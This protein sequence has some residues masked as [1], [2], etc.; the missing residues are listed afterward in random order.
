MAAG[1]VGRA[2]AGRGAGRRAE[3]ERDSRGARVAEVRGLKIDEQVDDALVDPR[4]DRRREIEL[5]G[6]G[7]RRVYS[8]IR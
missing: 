3:L 4:G 6:V 2:G 5:K 1:R 7:P 8:V